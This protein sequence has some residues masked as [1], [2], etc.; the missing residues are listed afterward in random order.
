[1]TS[2]EAESNCEHMY[3]TIVF[4]LNGEQKVFEGAFTSASSG[5]VAR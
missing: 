2:V 3:Q 1:M 4:M 5:L